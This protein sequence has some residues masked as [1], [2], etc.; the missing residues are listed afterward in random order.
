[1]LV[2]SDLLAF[3]VRGAAERVYRRE[4]IVKKREMC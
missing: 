2:S 4:K 3:R 1:M